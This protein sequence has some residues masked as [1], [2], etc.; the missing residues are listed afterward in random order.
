MPSM[1]VQLCLVV[2]TIL[3]GQVLLA[4]KTAEQGQGPKDVL[5]TWNLKTGQLGRVDWGTK[6]YEVLGPSQAI[7]YVHSEYLL[8]P[9]EDIPS[10][11]PQLNNPISVEVKGIV[12]KDLADGQGL[13]LKGIFRVQETQRKNGGTIFVLEESSKQWAEI[14]R[15]ER[16][17]T[18]KRLNAE[19]NARMQESEREAA[20]K[21]AARWRTW[22][23]ADGTKIG[24]ARYMSIA[25]G[26]VRLKREDGTMLAVP[27]D[28]LCDEDRKWLKHRR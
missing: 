5:H 3:N 15:K 7:L 24:R 13:R 26:K 1:T 18:Q 17:E 21:E 10:G 14:E 23:K 11:L 8:G 12:T 19:H 25:M 28:E 27:R 6:I 9:T 22:T 2:T 16:D 4:Q 20:A